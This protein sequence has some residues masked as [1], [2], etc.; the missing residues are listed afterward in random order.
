MRCLDRNT[1]VRLIYFGRL[2]AEKGIETALSTLVVLLARGHAVEL[3]L[4]GDGP[5]AFVAELRQRHTK[6]PVTWSTALPVEAILQR[7][8]SAHFFIFA[9]R[10]DGEGHSNALNEAMSLGLVPVCSDQGF[11]RSVV[12]DAGVVLSVAAQ[13]S[14]YAA[15]IEDILLTDSW[16]TL[17]Q[18]ARQRVRALY[19]EEAT[20]PPL[21]DT[22]RR[23]LA[24][25]R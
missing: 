7:A 3:E 15:V 13:A 10:H 11:T 12:G 8:A 21:I 4:I 6:L 16:A 22:Y 20:L 18:R 23:M 25:R 24:D 1:P 14:D 17:S 9:S 19:S 2:V 5:A